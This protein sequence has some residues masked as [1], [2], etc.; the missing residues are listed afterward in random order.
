MVDWLNYSVI[1]VRLILKNHL[2]HFL[3]FISKLKHFYY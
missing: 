3:T 2:R 1:L